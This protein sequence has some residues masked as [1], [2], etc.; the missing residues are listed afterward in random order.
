MSACRGKREEEGAQ[1]T[2]GL[3]G[4]ARNKGKGIGFGLRSQREG[5]L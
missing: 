4:N 1:R 2:Q 5:E 3:G